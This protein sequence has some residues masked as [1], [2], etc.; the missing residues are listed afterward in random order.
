MAIVSSHILDSTNGKSAAGVRVVLRRRDSDGASSVAF[1]IR[2]DLEGRIAETIDLE[3]GKPG[4]Y[5]LEFHAREYFSNA[6][7][8]LTDSALSVV[9]LRFVIANPDKRYHMPIMLS[10][11]SYSVWVST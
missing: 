4:E 7:V 11:H 10:P 9:V 6:G 5:D 3:D 2:A 1:D 8:A